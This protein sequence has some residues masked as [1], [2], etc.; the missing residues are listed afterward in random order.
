MFDDCSKC[1]NDVLLNGSG[2]N[3]TH[4]YTNTLKP[5]KHFACT[6]SANGARK[7]NKLVVEIVYLYSH[8]LRSTV[9]IGI[10]RIL[11]YN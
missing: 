9:C 4:T 6:V 8:I 7:Q 11:T 2:I 1:L 3:T 10:S 5:A